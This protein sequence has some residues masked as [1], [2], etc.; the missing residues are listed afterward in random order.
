MRHHILAL[1][2]TF[3]CLVCL[4]SC[5]SETQKDTSPI[6]ISW[7][8]PSPDDLR[9]IGPILGG[10]GVT[11]CGSFYV[12]RYKGETKVA[13]T[14]GGKDFIYYDIWEASENVNRTPTDQYERFNAPEGY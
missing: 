4:G 2:S 7:K 9:T 8:S 6:H 5:A 12:G 14:R 10:N 3:V 11:G 1:L 13:C